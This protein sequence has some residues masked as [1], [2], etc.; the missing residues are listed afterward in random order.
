MNAGGS[1]TSDS[2]VS[3][4]SEKID[5]TMNKINE[6][7]VSDAHVARNCKGIPFKN[8]QTK[9]VTFNNLTIPAHIDTGFE[10]SVC[11]TFQSCPK[12]P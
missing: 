11:L 8:V 7:K 10:C 5:S 2:I 12:T 4:S 3:D 1:A 6:K 9:E